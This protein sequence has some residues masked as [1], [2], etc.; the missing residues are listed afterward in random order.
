M[1][2]FD[3]TRA[4]LDLS[5]LALPS[6]SADR[7]T[8]CARLIGVAGSGKSY[9]LGQRVKADPK[10][11][12]LTATTGIAA[13]NLGGGAVTLNATLSYFDLPSMSEAFLTG[14]LSRKLHQI[15]R[16]YRWLVVEEYSMLEDLA[17]D[18]LRKACD[19]ANRYRDVPHPLGILLVG[20]LAQ[21]PPV[22][23]RWSFRADCWPDFA[24]TTERLT[25]VWRQDG[26][27]FLDAL[28]A[29]RVGDGALAAT[30]LTD[31]GVEWHTA[32]DED[33]DGT[34]ILPIN[35]QVNRHNDLVLARLPGKP[36]KV[37]ARRWGRQ[38]TE[39]GLSTRTGEWGIPPTRDLK[40]GATVMILANAPDFHYVNGDG[41]HIVDRYET[42]SGSVESVDI[43]L[44][45]TRQV[46]S[47]GKL[48][49]G[50][51]TSTKP[52]D[53]DDNAPRLTP[54]EDLG[55]WFAQPHW[56]GKAR[57]Y[58]L[59]QLEYLPVTVGY[60][61]TVHKSQ[62]LTLDRIQVDIRHAFFGAPAM[63]YVALSR[64]RTL[65][66]LRLVGQREVFVKRCKVDREVLPWL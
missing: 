59:G 35:K 5:Q 46:V 29:L 15:A 6:E 63:T 62:S 31:A 14:Q 22:S 44:F 38:R 40:L 60:A 42:C 47:I 36:F 18:L 52:P 13:M 24:A 45:R 51:E 53:W 4:D 66:G 16:E 58:V 7:I 39:W 57:R 65:E 3:T 26:G 21:L 20:D 55:E 11:G 17:L 23:G 8:P 54:G 56:R 10:Y 1:H 48:V 12:L 34:T 2:S 50:V 19:E 28:N 30:L 27:P 41:G 32:R 61:S 9:T 43:E 25:K 37:A 49:R 33:F 64:V